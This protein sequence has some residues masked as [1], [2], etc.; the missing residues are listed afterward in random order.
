VIERSR[1][2]RSGDQAIESSGVRNTASSE[3]EAPGDVHPR[4]PFHTVLDL[5]DQTGLANASP[6]SISTRSNA[7]FEILTCC[8]PLFIWLL[9]YYVPSLFPFVQ[10]EL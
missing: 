3:I 8:S 10:L 9:R 2:N 5:D 4:D 1:R 7:G 6:A